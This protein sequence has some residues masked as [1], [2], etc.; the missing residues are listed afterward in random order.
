VHALSLVGVRLG[1]FCARSLEALQQFQ[2][3]RGLPV[4]DYCDDATWQTLIESTWALGSRLLYLTS[5]H[6]RGDDVEQLQV[7]LARLGFNCAKA[8]GVFGPLTAQGLSDFQQ[9]YGLE[10]DGICG[11]LT[12]KAMERIGG[13]SGDGPGVVAVREDELSRSV[14]ETSFSVVIGAFG[15]TPALATH[16]ARAM[17]ERGNRVLIVESDDPHRHSLAANSFRADLY[18]GLQRGDQGSVSFYKT[19]NYASPAGERIAALLA[20]ELPERPTV[21]GMRHAVL[22]ETRMPAILWVLATSPS[23]AAQNAE[24]LVRVAGTWWSEAH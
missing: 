20:S 19:E 24:A 17:R 10:V 9:N 23:D 5:P 7:R 6:L 3:R 2:R 22:R 12:L 13:Q 14:N 16:V 8:D 4:H 11:P 1:T 21:C 18:I 15:T